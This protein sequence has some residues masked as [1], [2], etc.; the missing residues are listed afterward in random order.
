M[1]GSNQDAI[2]YASHVHDKHDAC[3][4]CSI[5]GWEGMGWGREREREKEW[6]G[7]GGGAGTLPIIY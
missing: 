7:G 2:T 5:F 4:H 1:P 3:S 6:G